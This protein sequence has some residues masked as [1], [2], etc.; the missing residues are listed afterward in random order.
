M[1]KVVII[2]NAGGGKSV[3]SKKLAQAK[4]LPAYDV[5]RYQW[6]PGW[7]PVP[8]TDVRDDLN[9]LLTND[10]WIIDGWGPWDCIVRRFQQSDTIVFIDFPVWIHLWWA[11]KRQIRAFLLPWTIDKPEGCSLR[12]VTIR[13][14]RMI[15]AIDKNVTHKMRA[16]VAQH[17]EDRQV[18]HIASR[19]DFREFVSAHC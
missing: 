9:S 4:G 12:S 17:G 10:R 11:A 8:E 18:F 3:L 14:F 15:L 7:Q 1:S 2:G 13:L 16:L 5:D 6:N 19:K